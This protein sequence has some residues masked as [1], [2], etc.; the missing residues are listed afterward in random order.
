MLLLEN[1]PFW[2][3]ESNCFS[4]NHVAVD[5]FSCNST[6]CCVFIPYLCDIYNTYRSLLC[7]GQGSVNIFS[8]E[9][10]I[11]ANVLFM[12]IRVHL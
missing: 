4:L 9:Y 6:P 7:F 8:L 3:G 12:F 2:R 10:I 11:L 5:Y 1:N